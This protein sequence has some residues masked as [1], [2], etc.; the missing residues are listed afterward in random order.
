DIQS[1]LDSTHEL[2]LSY[3]DIYGKTANAIIYNLEEI[4]L[5]VDD[6]ILFYDDTEPIQILCELFNINEKE[7]CYMPIYSRINS[8]QTDHANVNKNVFKKLTKNS[9]FTNLND[10]LQHFFAGGTI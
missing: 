5:K 6:Y 3:S 10:V 4:L 1:K 7:L 2:C 8:I 9:N